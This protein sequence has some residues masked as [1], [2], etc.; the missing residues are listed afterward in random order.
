[1]LSLTRHV[2]HEPTPNQHVCSDAKLTTSVTY[3]GA[4]HAQDRISTNDETVMCAYH[5]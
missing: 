2:G 4:Q 5:L 3:G 1:M